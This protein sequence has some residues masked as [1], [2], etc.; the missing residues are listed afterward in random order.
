[1]DRHFLLFSGSEKWVR[2][3]ARIITCKAQ[4]VDRL[5]TLEDKKTNKCIN[6]NEN[7]DIYELYVRTGLPFDFS[8]AN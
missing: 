7:F 2:P 3:M 1:M 8:Q 5:Q 4:M 6:N